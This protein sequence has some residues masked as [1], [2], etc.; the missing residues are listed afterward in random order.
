MLSAVLSTLILCSAS[1]IPTVFTGFEQSTLENGFTVCL[2]ERPS[3]LYETVSVAIRGGAASQT[4][5]NAGLPRL[6]CTVVEKRLSFLGFYGAECVVKNE[7]LIFSVTV[8]REKTENAV[9]A[10]KNAIFDLV[11]KNTLIDDVFLSK[12]SAA[13]FDTAT[14]SEYLGRIALYTRL[15]PKAPWRKDVIGRY[16]LVS[17]L[18]KEEIALYCESLVSENALAIFAGPVLS[19]NVKNIAEKNLTSVPSKTDKAFVWPVAF[20]LPSI[21]R[22][23]YSLVPDASVPVGEGRMGVYYRGPG[24]VEDKLNAKAAFLWAEIANAPS[25]EFKQNVYRDVPL[26]LDNDGSFKLVYEFARDS[27]LLGFEAAFK[28]DSK[29]IAVDRAQRYFKE[30]VK[31]TEMTSF[32]RVASY[33][34][35]DDLSD[36]KSRFNARLLA[37]QDNPKE[38]THFICELWS[39]MGLSDAATFLNEVQDLTLDQVRYFPKKYILANLEI[40]QLRLNPLDVEKEGVYAKERLYEIVSPDTIHWYK[41]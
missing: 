17:A 29:Y 24:L 41:K 27:S 6:I 9:I 30:Q 21:K 16:E 34:T 39:S 36:V 8:P 33:F 28:L 32:N 4:D 5:K 1:A 14:F 10:L 20:T 38:Y 13:L 35:K 22:F 26:L 40:V 37:L 31:G 19:S 25:I 2:L 23:A 18:T 3:M 15:F 11:N 12:D 7:Y